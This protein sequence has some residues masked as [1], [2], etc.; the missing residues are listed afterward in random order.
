MSNAFTATIDSTIATTPPAAGALANK[1]TLLRAKQDSA[2]DVLHTPKRQQSGGEAS[3]WLQPANQATA[4]VPLHARRLSADVEQTLFDVLTA[5][6]AVNVTATI[7]HS[8]KEHAVGNVLAQLS[9]GESRVLL[10]R[11]Q[12]GDKHDRVVAAF[13]SLIVERRNRLTAF[14]ADTARRQAIARR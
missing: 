6:V 5:P 13:G 12:R 11:I 2:N 3:V 7:A 9:V 10:A 4:M 14:L 8:Q 1:V